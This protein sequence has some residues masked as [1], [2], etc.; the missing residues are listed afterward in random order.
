MAALSDETKQPIVLL[1]DEAQHAITTDGGY[2]ALVRTESRA[3]RAQQQRSISVCASSLRGPTVTSWRCCATA[4]TR[5]SSAR[6][7][8]HS[9]PSTPATS[10]G[11]AKVSAWPAR[12]TRM[13]VTKLF[14]RAGF[15]PEIFGAA[16][17]SLRFDFSIKPADAG[18]AFA[19]AVDQ[20]I[21]EADHADAAGDPR[22]HAPCSRPCCVFWRARAT[23]T[24]RSR[25]GPWRATERCL[26]HSRRTRQPYPRSPTSRRRS[27]RAAGQVAGLEREAGRLLPRRDHDRGAD[28]RS[29][30]CWMWRHCARRHR[31]E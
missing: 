1:I 4:R 16:A 24:R 8:S 18:A 29:T 14:E 28:A 19:K 25:P 26:L 20:Q 30:A 9:R 21:E 11:S 23:S 2:D 31:A 3:R 17:D 6:P 12:W 5:H 13:T 7:W 27:E 15:R 22:P 10:S